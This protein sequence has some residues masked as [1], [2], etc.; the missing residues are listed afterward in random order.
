M[1]DVERV[2]LSSAIAA[3]DGINEL[4]ARGITPELFSGTAAGQLCAEVYRWCV[5]YT[6][7]YGQQPS[8][9]ALKRAFDN[10]ANEFSAEPLHAL[11]DEFLDDA[12]KRYFDAAVLELSTVTKD[13]S[14]WGKLDEIMLD[15]ARGLAS[16]IP[17]GRVA[18]FSAEMEQ[19]I[20]Q[21]EIEANKGYRPG[22][23]L[24]IPIIDEVTGGIRPGWLI[25]SAGFSGLG[26]TT[27]GL[28]GALNVFES[29]HSALF[30]S[31]EMSSA[32]VMERLDTMVTN[33][34]HRDLARRAL[35]TSDLQ[36]WKQMGRV[37][38][39]AK[40]EIVVVDK[41]GGCTLDRVH[42]E[43]ARYRPQVAV[44][45][46]VQRMSGTRHS[47]SKWEGL[48][49][50]SNGLK[51][52]AMDT[53]T[54]IIMISQDGRGSAEEGSTRT[55]MGGSVAVYQAADMYLGMQQTDDMHAV[56]KMRVKML[57]FRHGP[58]AEV[59]MSWKPATGEFG[60]WE[61]PMAYVKQSVL[62]P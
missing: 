57:K 12:R 3:Q 39:K 36:H 48:E 7:A 42:A 10:W 44:I 51:T 40:G 5:Q 21:Y 18:R 4:M 49:E 54:A 29:D 13:R 47:M 46:Y 35:G 20:M 6:H 45:D 33:F 32:E 11:G 34:P 24:G 9:S 37:Y 62:T 28:F 2:M 1:A 60:K 38:G 26:K 17:S 19:R 53:D 14:N 50:I 52:I 23:Q 55:N 59:D 61:D 22:Y 16:I 41:L 8:L 31:L 15:R 25:T 27:L 30:L 56:G 43:I 58:R